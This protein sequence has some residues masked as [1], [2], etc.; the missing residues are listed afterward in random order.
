MKG[1]DSLYK[2]AFAF[3]GADPKGGS[4][5]D[6]INEIRLMAFSLWSPYIGRGCKGFQG[7]PKP[8]EVSGMNGLGL[9]FNMYI[10]RKFNLLESSPQVI[11]YNHRVHIH[12]ESQWGFCPLPTPAHQVWTTLRGKRGTV[13]NVG[14]ELRKPV[15]HEGLMGFWK[16]GSFQSE[17]RSCLWA[18]S[19]TPSHV[20]WF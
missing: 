7:T 16:S 17:D 8:K 1:R 9:N 11:F 13:G 20:V 15:T 18:F 5:G 10:F 12:H 4:S 19:Q 2:M 6:P 3:W 14:G